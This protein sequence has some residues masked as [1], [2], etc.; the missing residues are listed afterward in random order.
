MIHDHIMHL[1]QKHGWQTDFWDRKSLV[2]E[3]KLFEEEERKSFL[4]K[5]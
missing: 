1:Y 4:D 2:A 3:W 5:H